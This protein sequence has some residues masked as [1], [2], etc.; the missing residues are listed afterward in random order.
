MDDSPI[1][2][3]GIYA[4]PVSK[5]W[6]AITDKEKMEKWYF[7]IK[8][9]VPEKGKF[10]DFDI[11]E[12]EKL[13]HHHFEILEVVANKKLRHTW[14]H[15]GHSKG[16]SVLTWILEPVEKGTKVTL[17][18]EGIENFADAGDGFKKENYIAGWNEILG[19][20]LRNFLE[21]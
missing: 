13:Y 15:P 1:I 10:F 19:T 2:I 18:H 14:T 4:A 20:W 9:F 5:V 17:I 12:G 8:D 21:K 3:E 16:K 7:D 11:Q 6:E